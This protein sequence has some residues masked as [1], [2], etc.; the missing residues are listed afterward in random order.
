M[1]PAEEGRNSGKP[2]RM[3][4]Y[5]SLNGE[6]VGPV[7][8][9]DIRALVS[10]G[11]ITAS[12]LVWQ[13]GQRNWVPAAAMPGLFPK[14]PPLPPPGRPQARESRNK[15]W[16]LIGIVGGALLLL[17]VSLKTMMD[18]HNRRRQEAINFHRDETQRSLER[19]DDLFQQFDGKKN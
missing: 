8:E 4:W 2:L 13:T 1:G 9:R 5:Y 14:P 6:Q 16:I 3:G 11:Q 18:N 7:S 15:K 12:D 19:V 17:F 10:N